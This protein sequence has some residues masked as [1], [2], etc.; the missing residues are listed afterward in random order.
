MNSDPLISIV[1][2][3]YNVEKYVENCIESILDQTY[4]NWELIIVDDGSTDNSISICKNIL[5][6]YP[7]KIKIVTK[8]NGGLSD[9]RN[10]GT[11]SAK[12]EYLVYIDSDDIVSP[13]YL[14][15]LLSGLLSSHSDVSTCMYKDIPE[16]NVHLL[17]SLGDIQRGT[18]SNEESLKY[19]LKDEYINTGAW[20]KLA[21]TSF[22]KKFKFPKGRVYEDL[23]TI[24]KLLT[25]AKT[26]CYT[27]EMLY[28]HVMRAGSLSHQKS[29]SDNQI[30]D[31][32]QGIDERFNY[33][34]YRFPSLK[35]LLYANR[36]VEYLRVYYLI[37][38]SNY[39]N[40]NQKRIA[41]SIEVVIKL[42]SKYV[43]TY[44]N[45]KMRIKCILFL[46]SKKL[47][48]YLINHYEKN[49]YIK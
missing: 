16:Q 36:V 49:K 3:V 32:I 4:T 7:D 33:L 44:G 20:G 14:N 22:W 42:N 5:D 24:Y 6:D 23:S 15:V 34:D 9:A 27:N 13:R 25:E 28:G 17:D 18:I 10:F 38:N 30:S 43:I 19:L 39:I 21:K 35:N 37:S 46:M 45:S 1:M 48:L 12:G 26:V 40:N 11:A 31:Y 2:P 47:Y 8:S 41:K 29:V